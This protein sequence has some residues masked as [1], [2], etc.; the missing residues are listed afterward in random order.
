[1]VFIGIAR[2]VCEAGLAAVRS[3]MI[4]PDLIVQGIGSQAIGAAGVF[5]LSLAYIWS[6]DI[7]IFLLAMVANGLKLIQT[8]DR[9]SRRVVCWAVVAAIFIGAAG[10]CWM[11]FHLAYEYGGINLDSWRFRGG[12]STSWHRLLYRQD[13][14]HR[15]YSGVIPHSLTWRKGGPIS[16][17]YESTHLLLLPRRGT[18]RLRRSL[19]RQK[20]AAL[21][22][23]SSRAQS[24]LF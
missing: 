12:P 8:M 4:A 13:R 10:S 20:G 6:A 23:G 21:A 5:N 14:Q 3:P 15:L 1:M 22:C 9:R 11:V 16:L 2:V 19:C 17:R 18:R 7:R 24:D